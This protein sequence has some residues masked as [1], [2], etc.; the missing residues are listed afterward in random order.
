MTV[1][2]AV[3]RRE[4]GTTTVETLNSMIDALTALALLTDVILRACA[5]VRGARRREAPSEDGAS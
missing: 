1:T 3:G 4:D 5:A 2:A